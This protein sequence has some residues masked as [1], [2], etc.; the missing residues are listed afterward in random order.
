MV[1]FKGNGIVWDSKKNKLLCKFEDGIFT[2]EDERI[3]D[4]LKSLNYENNIK[5]K[6]V[7]EEKINYS[8]MTNKELKLILEK[9]GYENLDRKNK[10]QLINLIE[11]D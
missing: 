9:K 4:I 5:T 8:E 3:I 7:V 10:K 1:T 6:I 2:T 11:G